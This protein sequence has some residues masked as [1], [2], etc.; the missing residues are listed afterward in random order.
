MKLS[1]I[2]K[3]HHLHHEMYM[4]TDYKFTRREDGYRGFL[5][6]ILW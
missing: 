3:N 6:H 1:D 2:E 4:L 5:K